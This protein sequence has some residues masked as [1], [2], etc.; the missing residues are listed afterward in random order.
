[1]DKDYEWNPYVD[2]SVFRVGENVMGIN[3]SGFDEVLL[4]RIAKSSIKLSAGK[5][6]KSPKP[7]ALEW[8]SS[9]TTN[10]AVRVALSA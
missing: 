9:G 3:C 1:M 10:L 7:Q 2:K 6:C 8:S 4:S 5:R